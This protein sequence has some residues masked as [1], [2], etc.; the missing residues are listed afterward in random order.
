MRSIKIIFLLFIFLVIGV[1]VFAIPPQKKIFEGLLVESG[2]STQDIMPLLANIAGRQ[3]GYFKRNGYFKRIYGQY[4]GDYILIIV[5]SNGKIDTAEELEEI[6]KQ[7][8][9]NVMGAY[10][11]SFKRGKA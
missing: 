10:P 7:I 2:T 5:D 9:S 6:A 3:Q 11:L 8:V 1:D 4:R